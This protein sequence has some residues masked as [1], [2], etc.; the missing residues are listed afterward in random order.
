VPNI[1]Y[2][3]CVPLDIDITLHKKIWWTRWCLHSYH[4]CVPHGC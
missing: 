2:H 4:F 1:P 3:G